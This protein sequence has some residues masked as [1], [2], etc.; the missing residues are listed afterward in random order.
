MVKKVLADG[1]PGGKP[2]KLYKLLRRTKLA[3]NKLPVADGR[4][5]LSREY[6]AELMAAIGEEH[7]S[8]FHRMIRDLD[9]AG[10]LS[11]EHEKGPG[12]GAYV[13]VY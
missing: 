6:V 11:A 7:S 9:D 13:T 3:I 12:K 10:F 1:M 5:H 4:I 2:G 8:N